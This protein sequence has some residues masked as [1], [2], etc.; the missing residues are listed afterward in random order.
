MIGPGTGVAPFVGFL[1]HRLQEAKMNGTKFGKMWLFY[2][3]RHKERDYL[4]REDLQSFKDQ[5]ILSELSVCFSR[6]TVVEG[7]PNKDFQDS[8]TPNGE[9]P[10]GEPPNGEPPNE[11]PPNG[12]PP[13]GEPPNGEPPNEWTPSKEP[14]EENSPKY[15]QDSI[16]LNAGDVLR[17]TCDEGAV[18]YVCGDAKNMARDVNDTFVELLKKYR[19]IEDARGHMMKMR[20]KKQYHEDIWT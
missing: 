14:S 6:D 7:S 4:Y 9:P 2:G 17:W 11:E 5:G 1:S 10:N 15:V 20:L 8:G 13:N 12:E 3:C 16:R 19:G 18:V